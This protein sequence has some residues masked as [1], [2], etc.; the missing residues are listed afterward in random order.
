[1]NNKR[2]LFWSQIIITLFIS[3]IYLTLLGILLF[4][5]LDK[6]HDYEIWEKLIYIPILHI[7]TQII[8]MSLIRKKTSIL[9]GSICLITFGGLEYFTLWLSIM[10]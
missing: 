6:L 7:I 8:F 9:F 3:I 4:G 2:N 1:M 5:S 10:F